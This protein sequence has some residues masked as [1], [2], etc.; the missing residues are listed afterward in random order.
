MHCSK[1][2]PTYEAIRRPLHVPMAGFLKLFAEICT[3]CM[4]STLLGKGFP[5][6]CSCRAI[7]EI[8]RAQD[9]PPSNSKESA[10]LMEGGFFTM[11][12]K[13]CSISLTA[14][15]RTQHLSAGGSGQ[16]WANCSLTPQQPP[17]S[18]NRYMHW[19][20]I[21]QWGDNHQ[22]N[23]PSIPVIFF[24]RFGVATF[25]LSCPHRQLVP[26]EPLFEVLGAM[27][28]LD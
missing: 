6:S 14:P 7:I 10:K 28:Y 4:V 3:I 21:R 12:F 8:S 9:C 2:L 27:N 23:Y 5:S 20:L 18:A 24:L 25:R 11:Y 13:P 19:I 1:E 15:T 17:K 26:K 22:A 16:K